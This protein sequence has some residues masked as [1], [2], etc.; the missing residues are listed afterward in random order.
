MTL[1]CDSRGIKDAE[2]EAEANAAFATAFYDHEA[3]LEMRRDFLVREVVASR[4]ALLFMMEQSTGDLEH[5]V[6]SARRY[7]IQLCRL[8]D[9]LGDITEGEIAD[10]LMYQESL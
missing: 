5:R 3:R 1:P 6:S 8:V 7:A 4:G 2:W 9:E 10:R